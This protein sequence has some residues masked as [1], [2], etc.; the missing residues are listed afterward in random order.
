MARIV[1]LFDFDRTIIDGD[2][3]SWV[4]TEMGLTPLFDRLL[5]TLPWNSVMDRMMKELH[6]QGRT[7]EDIAMCLKRA[8]LD[9]Q[10][11]SAINSAHALGCD[12]R[13]ISDANQFFIE[14]ILEHHGL[15]GCFSQ[16]STNPTLVDEEGRLSIQPYHDPR[17]SPHGCRLC[18]ANM[19]KG[20]VFEHIR[21][22][23]SFENGK[24]RYIYLGDGN[25]DFCPTLKLGESDFVMPRKNYPLNARICSNPALVKAEVH[26]WSDGEEL[27][28][29]L[30]HLINTIFGED[31]NK[32]GNP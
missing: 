25:G 16:I 15:L 18:H 5:S 13:V 21:S 20:L 10:I 27:K 8:P 28:K 6:S 19:C 3:D 7:V 9:P 26:E 1:V 17:S 2:S 24:V 32:T 14:T 29:I 22:R 11:I 23:S 30:L 31:N 12:L 4:V